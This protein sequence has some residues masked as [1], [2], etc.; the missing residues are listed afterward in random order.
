MILQKCKICGKEF[1]A[2][3]KNHTICSPECRQKNNLA[4]GI[5]YRARNRQEMNRKLRRKRREKAVGFPCK[6]CGKEVKPFFD[7]DDRPHRYHWH[8]ECLINECIRAIKNGE[9]TYGGVLKF[10]SNKGFNKSEIL[11]IMEEQK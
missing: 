4:N 6:F 1:E 10:A 11:E 5:L 7:A 8:E 3:Q 2:R 9:K